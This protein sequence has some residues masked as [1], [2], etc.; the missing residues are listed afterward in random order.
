MDLFFNLDLVENID[1]A[2]KNITVQVNGRTL[3]V[4]HKS[5]VPGYK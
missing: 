4:N 1:K 2:G 5:T 3:A